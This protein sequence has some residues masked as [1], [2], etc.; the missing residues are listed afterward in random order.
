M[1]KKKKEI[2]HKFKCLT[3]S[4]QFLK[5]DK[6]LK[7]AQEEQKNNNI[8][9]NDL[10]HKILCPKCEAH[11]LQYLPSEVKSKKGKKEKWLLKLYEQISSSIGRL[12]GSIYVLFSTIW[13]NNKNSLFEKLFSFGGYIAAIYTLIK[14][15]GINPLYSCLILLVFRFIEKLK[16]GVN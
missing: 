14:L 6:I 9:P 16:S 15:F 11:T 1:F 13:N 3:C 2:I 12:F 10:K 8:H 7:L 4:N 5:S